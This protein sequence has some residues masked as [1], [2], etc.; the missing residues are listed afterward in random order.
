LQIVSHYQAAYATPA[1]ADLE[2]LERIQK[3]QH[4]LFAELLPEDK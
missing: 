1:I 3:C 4:L 2:K